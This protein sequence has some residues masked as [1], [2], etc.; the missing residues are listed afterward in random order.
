MGERLGI[1]LAA[2][3]CAGAANAAAPQP[4]YW[5]HKDWRSFGDLNMRGDYECQAMTGGDGDNSFLVMA[6]TG[7]DVSVYFDEV[8]ARGYP[9]NLQ[10]GDYLRFV[11]TGAQPVVVGDV[12]AYVDEG[13]PLAQAG[14]PGG[15]SPWVVKALRAGSTVRVE[16]E[17][18][19]GGFELLGEF[20]LSGFTANY[21]KLAEWCG[22]DP[23]IRNNS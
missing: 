21:L 7:G 2:L 12:I 1:T 9:T 10:N 15:D 22:F 23:D 4:E 16:R 17:T 8:T 6:G 14:P 20:S 3:L 19:G 5:G 18:A 11:I 13:I